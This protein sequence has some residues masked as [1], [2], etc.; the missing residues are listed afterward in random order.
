MLIIVL[1]CALVVSLFIYITTG[2]FISQAIGMTGVLIAFYS[3]GIIPIYIPSIQGVFSL[4]YFLYTRSSIPSDETTENVG[5]DDW[6]AYGNKLKSAYS[7]KFGSANPAFNDDVDKH[8][9]VMQHCNKGFTST[10]AYE[11]LKRMKRFT[12]SK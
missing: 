10:L 1:S 9:T 8:I 5:G 7:A 6:V 11:W 12:E 4:I 3:L 2:S